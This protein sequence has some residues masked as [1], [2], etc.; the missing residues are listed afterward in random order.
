M[1]RLEDSRSVSGWLGGQEILTG[2]IQTVDEVISLVDDV[3]AEELQV[4]AEDL[5]IGDKIRV[6]V[7]GPVDPDEPL[8][9]LLKL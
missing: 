1:L 3:T 7:V 6:A 4:I 2:E 9:E 5:M 8:V